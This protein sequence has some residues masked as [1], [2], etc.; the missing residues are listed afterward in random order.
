MILWIA[1]FL[2]PDLPEVRCRLSLLSSKET[3][4]EMAGG[5]LLPAGLRGLRPVKTGAHPKGFPKKPRKI[6]PILAKSEDV[7]NY[8]TPDT[9]VI[10]DPPRAGCDPKL[11]EKLA[12]IQPPTIVYLSCN[13]ITQARDIAPLLER[14]QIDVCQPFNFFPRTPHIENLI[15]LERIS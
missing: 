2:E 15:V 11:I 13:P 10:L 5:H 9:T 7:L 1:Q 3:V 12:E 8:I 6:S 4:E 14:Y